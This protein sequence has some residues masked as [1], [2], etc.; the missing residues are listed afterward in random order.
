M[1]NEE[2]LD[3]HASDTPMPQK[4]TGDRPDLSV[5]IPALREAQNLVVLLPALT[6]VLRQI[7]VRSEILIVT[8]DPDAATLDAA[9]TWGA[10]VIEQTAPGYGQAL[11]AGFAR[12]RGQYLMTMDAD[13]SHP[14]V[15]IRDLWKRRHEAE[16]TVASRYVPG[17]RTRMPRTRYALSVVLNQ[18][19]SRGL[20]LGIRDMSSGFRLYAAHVLR[21]AE[22]RAPG[23]DI[24]QEILVR[25][26]MGGWR[27]QEVP[28][29]YVPREHG[30]SHARVFR[31]GLAFARTFWSLWK[32]RNSI[33]A[34]DYDDRAYDSPIPLQRYWQRSRFRHVTAL[35]D[36]QGAVLD[37]GCGSS[38]IISALPA[39]SVAL[40]VLLH[41]VRY[42]RKFGK[43][44]A[45]GSGV[46]LPFRNESFPCVVCSQV[47][48]HVPKESPI[49][50]ELCRVLA[51]GGRLVLGTPDYARWE[52]RIT[53]RLYGFFAPGAYA[54][55][56]IAHYTRGELIDRFTSQGFTLEATRYILRGELILAFRKPPRAA[57]A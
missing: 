3:G 25:V 24:L 30:T 33:L 46:S 52:W 45:V 35:I 41:K 10:E 32:L 18:I 16:I 42:A 14:P 15:F 20:S 21:G 44:L 13:L 8:S 26:Y 22:F 12:A 6:D 43:L 50:A 34:A 48:E 39:G 9:A 27:V 29:E 40:D 28:F 49:L 23:F 17:G 37:V 11:T 55:E 31:F 56:H 54:D 4:D 36:A 7:G 1:L 19:F 47:I 53:E 51:P 57:S 38:R 2:S 5:I